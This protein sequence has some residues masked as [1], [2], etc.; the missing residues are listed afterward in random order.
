MVLVAGFVGAAAQLTT[1][2]T[3]L[4]IHRAVKDWCDNPGGA[5]KTWG[6]ISHWDVTAIT[7]LYR[8]FYFKRQFNDDISS[9]DV[10]SVTDMRETFSFASS[11]NSDISE[12]N[13]HRVVSL[14]DTFASALSFNQNISGWNTTAVVN[15]W[16][17]FLYASSFTHDISSWDV[18]GVQDFGYAFASA[19]SFGAHLCWQISETADTTHM[20]DDTAACI[21]PEC[22]SAANKSLLC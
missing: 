17:T 13:T 6:N 8:L 21:D 2:L 15:M 10:S 19:T 22:G 20:F 14:G 12:W 4:N 16:D 18:A 1:P 11:F 7:T 3:D 5:E 9:W